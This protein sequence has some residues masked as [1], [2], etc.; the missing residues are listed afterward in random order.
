MQSTNKL[1]NVRRYFEGGNRHAKRSVAEEFIKRIPLLCAFERLYA[2]A[3][4]LHK[5]WIPHDLHSLLPT[6][7]FIFADNNSYRLAV[8]G[9]G[10]Y[11]VPSLDCVY[12]LAK[13]TL[14]F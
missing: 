10:Y 2:F 6:L 14:D 12:Q 9:N 11:L 1:T 7:V 3:D 8:T 4:L 13:L 5:L